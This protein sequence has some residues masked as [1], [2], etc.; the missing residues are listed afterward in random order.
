MKP[1]APNKLQQAIILALSSPL[2]WTATPTFAGI[3]EAE[4][5]G[6]Y[7]GTPLTVDK[8]TTPFKAFA[9]YG[10]LNQGWTHSAQFMTLTVGSEAEISSGKSYDVQLTMRGR[11]SLGNAGA[12]AIDNPAFALWTAG[13]GKLSPE[14]AF[15]Q[16]G[17][18][19][20][21]G[22]NEAAINVAGAADK[23]T[24]NDTLRLVGVLDGHVGWIGYVN[25]GP[26]YTMDNQ[27]DPLGGQSLTLSGKSVLDTVSHGGLNTTSNAW[28]TNPSASST[29][30]TN[31]YFL[32]GDAMTGTVSDSATMTLYGL[33]AGRYLIATGGSC[34]TTPAPKTVCG[35]GSQ[36]TFTVQPIPSNSVQFTDENSIP[37]NTDLTASLKTLHDPKDKS[38]A[39]ALDLQQ[40]VL[41]A[42]TKNL[43]QQLQALPALASPSVS[44]VQTP[45]GTLTV[46]VGNDFYALSPVK[47]IKT[48]NE[49]AG[50][51][52]TQ[53]GQ[54]KVVTNQ[55]RMII[56][57]PYNALIHP[58]IKADIATLGSTPGLYITPYLSEQVAN[59]TIGYLLFN[60]AS[61]KLRQQALLPVPADWESL[62]STLEALNFNHV[63]LQTNGVI[64]VTD[65]D[66]KISQGIMVYQVTSSNT[67]STKLTFNAA[68]DVNN[69][70]QNDLQVSYPNGDKQTLILFK[71]PSAGNK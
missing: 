61:G 19:P 26:T 21:R 63:T 17:W 8:L 22:P 6:V 56:S 49:P 35:V 33:K 70:G 43:L 44:L 48:A 34:P 47:V 11:G 27:L 31:N 60:D 39:F 64:S 32:Q 66:G 23:L 62:R 58:A 46:T 30:Y 57:K 38:Q 15:G 68:G 29:A 54:I 37:D 18:N 59:I 3:R 69:D 9:D 42:P 10:A 16:H 1:I 51:S 5:I 40:E 20:T 4:N 7:N 36:F 52:F 67:A 41:P 24:I 14:Q 25:A 13:T 45:T 71:Q 65:S 50:I 2:L 12:A 55:Q 53:D 28:L